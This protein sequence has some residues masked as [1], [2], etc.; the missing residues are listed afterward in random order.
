MN[1]LNESVDGR[2]KLAKSDRCFPYC[3]T[4]LILVISGLNEDDSVLSETSHIYICMRDENS[5]V[6]LENSLAGIPTITGLL[7]AVIDCVYELEVYGIGV[8]VPTAHKGQ[9]LRIQ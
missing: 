8:I 9:K 4:L 2:S 6:L 1:M 7:E 3:S 5:I